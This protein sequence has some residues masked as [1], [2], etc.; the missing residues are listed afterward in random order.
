MI[1]KNNEA[2]SN[3]GEKLTSHY[4]ELLTGK[5]NMK[6]HEAMDYASPGQ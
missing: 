4:L 5:A 1:Q 6:S 2:T 3:T